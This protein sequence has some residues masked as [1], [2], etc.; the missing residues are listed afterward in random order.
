MD[1]SLLEAAN[2]NPPCL[3]HPPGASLQQGLRPCMGKARLWVGTVRVVRHWNRLSRDVVVV[4][5]LTF[6]ARLDQAVGN[7]T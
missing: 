6:K 7:L 1:E 4:P 2:E 3:L 5:P